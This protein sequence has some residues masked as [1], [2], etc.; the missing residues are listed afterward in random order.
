MLGIVHPSG[1]AS[2]PKEKEL[3]EQIN[4]LMTDLASRN[5]QA[6]C[7][8]GRSPTS[9]WLPNRSFQRL[10][11]EAMVLADGPDVDAKAETVDLR[12][13]VQDCLRWHKGVIFSGNI[14]LYGSPSDACPPAR[15]FYDSPSA[16]CPVLSAATFSSFRIGLM[17]GIALCLAFLACPSPIFISS[18]ECRGALVQSYQMMESLNNL[19]PEIAAEVVSM[20]SIPDFFQI[21]MLALHCNFHNKNPD[22]E[23][24]DSILE[25]L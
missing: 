13:A 16:A 11:S 2:I 20:K 3:A 9:P 22:N 6:E 8:K 17:R 4:Q 7:P 5:F 21:G 10:A 12:M 24:S 1:P 15:T 14:S 23:V 25:R 19:R 18:L